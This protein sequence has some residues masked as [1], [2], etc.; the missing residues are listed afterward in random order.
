[1]PSSVLADYERVFDEVD[2]ASIAARE[3]VTRHDVKARIE[4][5]NALAGHEHI[6]KGMTCRDLTENV[7][8]LQIRR[9]LELVRRTASRCVARLAERAIELPRPGDG[10]PLAQ[11]RRAGHHA[12]QAVRDGGRRDAGRADAAARADRPLPAARHQGPDGHRA[13]HARPARRRRRASWPSSSGGSPNTS[14]STECSPA[15]GRSTRARSTS[16]SSPRW[17]SSAAGP[18]VAGAH[19]PADGRPRAGD[20]GLR[21]GPG[22]LVG[23]AAQDEHPLLR[24]GQRAAGRAARLRVDGRRAGR[25][26]VERG[27]RVLLGGA[28][29]RA[30]RRVLRRRRAVRDV[31][32]RARRVRRLPGGDPARARPLPAV[33]GHHQGADG[34]GARRRRPR[35]RARGDQGARGRGRA[36]DAR[37]GRWSRT[38]STGWP[39]IRGCRW[40]GPRWT[41]RWPTSRRSPARRAIRSTGVVDAVDELVGRYPEA[42][43]YTSGAIL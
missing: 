12:G 32:D 13:G 30:A 1:M 35:G 10:R 38:C 42:A 36:G 34:R 31:P 37:E 41:R 9:S 39:P 21:A 24:A 6:H 14:A 25:R 19:D 43:K 11:R 33:P 2:L 17:C 22:R 28:P 7:E 18:V 27:R 5:F 4:E 29:G 20:R 26:P 3:R 15:S 8:Q 23:D 16:T 40:T